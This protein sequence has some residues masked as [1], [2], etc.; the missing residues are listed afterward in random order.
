M[1]LLELLAR[2]KCDV[3]SSN[4]NK[5]FER[6]IFLATMLEAQ[7]ETSQQLNNTLKVKVEQE[8]LQNVNVS[9]V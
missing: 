5:E 3:S 4:L 8:Q 1:L 2:S 6:Q 7:S 9:A